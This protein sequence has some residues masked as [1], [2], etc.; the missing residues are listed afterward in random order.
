[1]SY[2]IFL[3]VLIPFVLI[4]CFIPER[5]IY[6]SWDK[7]K[8]IGSECNY[9]FVL[10]TNMSIIQTERGYL[11]NTDREIYYKVGAKKAY[12]IEDYTYVMN[13]MIGFMSNNRNAILIVEGHADE[14]SKEKLDLNM[15]LSLQRASVI[16]DVILS[17]GV[18]HTR[19]KIYPYSYFAPKYTTNTSK[20]RR[21]DF[22]ALKC[23]NQL[24]N[25]NYYYSNYYSNYYINN[26][27]FKK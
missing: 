22:V 1:M 8:D 18:Y 23:E 5:R 9:N 21:V 13:E 12:N 19:V 27:N 3:F 24:S 17:F 25:Y 14:I 20:N 6:F 11:L 4:A 15:R 10:S 7:P 2:K 26:T 16:R